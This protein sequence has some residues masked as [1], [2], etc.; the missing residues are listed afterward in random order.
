MIA[1]TAA[2]P[3]RRRFHADHVVSGK[4]LRPLD[5]SRVAPTCDGPLKVQNGTSPTVDASHGKPA[6]A[7]A[8]NG[9]AATFRCTATQTDPVSESD[10]ECESDA[11]D[12]EFE[13]AMLGNGGPDE[14]GLM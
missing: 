9:T 12:E 1:A 14:D 5:P 13:T 4:P 3:E 6:E 2:S 11:A 8:K 7:I 10:S